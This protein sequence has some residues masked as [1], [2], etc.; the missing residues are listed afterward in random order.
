MRDEGETPEGVDVE[1][2][3]RDAVRELVGLGPVGP[4]LEDDEVSEIQC[5][6][7]DQ[8]LATKGGQ[9]QLAESSFTSEEALF[10]VIARLAQQSGDPWKPGELVLERRLPRGAQMLAITPPAANGHVLV[11]RKRRRVDMSLEDFVRSN[12]LSRP[13]AVFLE[14]CL[15]ARVNVLLS[16]PTSSAMVGFMAA[17][18][19]SGPQ[20]ER[21]S[22]L[23]DTDE[24]NVA[25]AHVVS[26]SIPDSRARGEETV[27]AATKLR[28][29]R[30]VVGSLVVPIAAAVLEAMAEGSEGVLAGISA[31]SLRQGLARVVS[32]VMM[33]RPGLGADAVREAL[34]DAFDVA[35]ELVQFPDGRLRVM[36]I[37]EPGG[38]DPKGIV[39]RDIFTAGDADGAFAASGV[40]PRVV[41]ELGA[42]GI[43]VDPNLFKRGR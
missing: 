40:V 22:V 39:L 35:V 34:A 14:N 12:A 6:R 18:A 27:R 2:L 25:H 3:V 33:A 5:V 9:V 8:V 30:L 26:L 20:G 19:S 28:P 17:L 37:V 10:R 36:R 4:L 29:E 32:Q 15:S 11:V 13:M 24:I 43:K 23:H 21:I 31:P 16:G 38:I 1:L 41:G 7:Q 42:R